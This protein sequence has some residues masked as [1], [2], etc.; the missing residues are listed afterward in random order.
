MKKITARR[1]RTTQEIREMHVDAGE[2]HARRRSSQTTVL[3]SRFTLS[4]IPTPALAKTLARECEQVAKRFTRQTPRLLDVSVKPKEV[5]MHVTQSQLAVHLGQHVAQ[6]Y[7]QW[8]PSTTVIWSRDELSKVV[9]VT[10]TFHAKRELKSLKPSRRKPKA[11][12]ELHRWS[13]WY[14]WQEKQQQK[15]K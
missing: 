2:R 12:A 15:K 13:E 4:A 10:V 6:S 7:K 1:T 8:T 14:A 9:D 5:S 11:G 3:L